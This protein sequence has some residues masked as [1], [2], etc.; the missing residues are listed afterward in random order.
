MRKA[1]ILFRRQRIKE[2]KEQGLNN[3]IVAERLRMREKDVEMIWW[4]IKTGRYNN[5]KVVKKA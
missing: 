4:K 1:E 3:K 5:Q 2:L